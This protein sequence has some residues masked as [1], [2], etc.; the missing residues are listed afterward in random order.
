MIEQH[1]LFGEVTPRPHVTHRQGVM[2][3]VVSNIETFART[4][5]VRQLYAQMYGRTFPV[6]RL[7]AWYGNRPYAFGGRVVEP[8]SEIPAT[9]RS[10]R[11]HVEELAGDQ[12]FDSCFVNYY[13]SGEDSIAWHSDDD[14]WIGP[15]IASVSFGSA[16]RFRMRHKSTG[17]TQDFL[18]GDGDLLVMHA[19]TQQAWEH[20]VPPQKGAGPRLNL[21]FRQT[22]VTT[23]V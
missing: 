15:V 1:L 21:T 3:G 19:G 20:C 9:L 13:R 5:G 7:E 17:T 2:R 22:K 6:P 12:R 14:D 11:R 18:L 10:L 16:R 23:G 4:L 8:H